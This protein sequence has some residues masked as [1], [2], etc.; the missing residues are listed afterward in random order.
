[1]PYF[2]NGKILTKSFLISFIKGKPQ[3]ID[4]LPDKVK[5]EKLSKDILY[6]VRL[7]LIFVVNCFCRAQCIWANV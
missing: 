5:L 1:M 7:Y 6:S 2:K 3:Y 4:Y